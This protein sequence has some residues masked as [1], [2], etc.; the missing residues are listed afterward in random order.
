MNKKMLGIITVVAVLLVSAAAYLYMPIMA[1]PGDANDPLVTRRYV[2]D[3][4]SQ[5]EDEI[6]VLRHLLTGI[7]PGGTLPGTGGA[8]PGAGLGAA[9]MDALFA[10]VMLYFELM[11]GEMLRA[12]AGVTP[13]DA[14]HVPAGTTMVFE[15]GA[16]FILR[17]GQGRV[18]AGPNGIVDATAGRDVGNGEELSRNHLMMV[19]ATDGR[20]V[21]FTTDVWIMIRGGYQIVG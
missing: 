16:E 17:T 8:T 15:R 14:L 4:I 6:A 20:G 5:L 18:V 12:A 9:D 19:P 21:T 11:Y 7:P 3:R 13:F 10:E 2:D 1:Q